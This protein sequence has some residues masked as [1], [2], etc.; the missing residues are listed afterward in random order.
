MRGP[1]RS[2]RPTLALPIFGLMWFQAVTRKPAATTSASGLTPHALPLLQI[3]DQAPNR[4]STQFFG[5]LESITGIS[6]YLRKPTLAREWG[7]SSERNSSTSSTI[8]IS[9]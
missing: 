4:G 1:L 2:K 6:H 7:S 3:L 8:H 9:R 5:D